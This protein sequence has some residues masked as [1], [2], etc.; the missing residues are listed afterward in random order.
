MELSDTL[1]I[2]SWSGI[3]V[4]QA[5]FSAF[6]QGNIHDA[7]ALLDDNVVWHIDGDLNVSTVGLLQGRE[8]VKCWLESFPGN[9]K[10]REFVIGE[11]IE[12]QDSVLA[13][14]HFRHTVLSTGNTVGSDMVIHFK[15]SQSKITRYQIFEDSALL[16]RAFDPSDEWQRQQIRINGTIYRYWECGEGPAIVFTHGLFVDHNAFAEQ[17]ASLSDSYR[18]IV[19]DMPGH[20]QSGYN[21]VGWT[22]D[23]LCGDLALMIKELSL[24]S[25]IFVGQSQGGM[26][27]IRLAAG[28]PE[29]ISKLIL[30]G[31]SARAELP[32]RLD[33]WKSQ[34]EILLNGSELQREEVFAHIQSHING[35]KWLLHS[36]AEVIR[37]REIMLAHDKN[38]LALALDAAVF[39]RGDIRQLLKNVTASTLIICGESDTATPIELSREMVAMIPKASLLTL[40]GVGHHPMLEAPKDVADAIAEFLC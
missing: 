15:L 8:Q 34:R 16:S 24:G 35:H 28:Y 33:N 36:S 30:I 2:S 11:L 21:P 9:F 5:Y 12:H 19:L 17:V 22:L 26:V 20:G 18:C 32:E 4:V 27:G 6:S 39:T 29:L 1:K 13:L 38:G 40:P 25:V 10:P 37:E 23:D 14:G 7:I 3:E 31:T